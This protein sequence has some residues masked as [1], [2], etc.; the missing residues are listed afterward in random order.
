MRFFKLCKDFLVNIGFV[1]QRRVLLVMVVIIVASWLLAGVS[2]H[3]DP[4]AHSIG[5]LALVE[6]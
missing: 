3:N 1:L 4:V 5:F 2:P 6:P